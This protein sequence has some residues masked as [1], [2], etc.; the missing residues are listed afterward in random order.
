MRLSFVVR[1][2]WKKAPKAEGIASTSIEVVAQGTNTKFIRWQVIHA[3][4]K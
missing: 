4:T 3:N 1:R 2:T